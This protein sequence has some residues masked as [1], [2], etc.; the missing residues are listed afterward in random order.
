VKTCTSCNGRKSH[1][2]PSTHDDEI[3]MRCRGTGH[4][5]EPPAPV[6][7]MSPQDFLKKQEERKPKADAKRVNLALSIINDHL[8]QGKPEIRFDSGIYFQTFGEDADERDLNIQQVMSVLKAAGWIVGTV[9]GPDSFLF[10]LSAKT[11]RSPAITR[12]GNSG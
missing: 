11:Q 12:S 9:S 5:P 1:H 6:K 10:K 7:V 8:E 2:N 4:D 3:C